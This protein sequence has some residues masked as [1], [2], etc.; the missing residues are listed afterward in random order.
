MCID[1]I[2]FDVLF[3]DHSAD[4]ASPGEVRKALLLH[5]IELN[6]QL[7]IHEYKHDWLWLALHTGKDNYLFTRGKRHPSILL[8]GDTSTMGTWSCSAKSEAHTMPTDLNLTCNTIACEEN[9]WL[10]SGTVM[11]WKS[12][13]SI[14]TICSRVTPVVATKLSNLTPVLI[15]SAHVLHCGKDKSK[16]STSIASE[17]ASGPYHESYSHRSNS[18][19]HLIFKSNAH[20][21]LLAQ[22]ES[23]SR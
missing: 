7:I 5:K 11:E 3:F 1:S 9:P 15:L 19:L 23:G 8:L 21:R 2:F 4:Q 22:L 10:E 20:L 13:N 6:S 16:L 14:G 17:R 12:G 18:V